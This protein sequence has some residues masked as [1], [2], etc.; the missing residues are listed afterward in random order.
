LTSA[1]AGAAAPRTRPTA[2]AHRTSNLFIVTS[3][4]NR[5]VGVAEVGGAP[6]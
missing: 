6:R 1:D 5:L 4:T 3:L 2:R